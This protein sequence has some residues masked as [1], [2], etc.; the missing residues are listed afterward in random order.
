MFFLLSFSYSANSQSLDCNDPEPICTDT[1]FA[2]T[3]NGN[4]ENVYVTNPGNNYDCLG[5]S[6]SPSWYYLEIEDDGDINMSL[7]APFDIDYI[8]WGP[9]ADL[10]QAEGYCGSLGV[11][12][13]N[14]VT[15]SAASFTFEACD[16]DDIDVFY[17]SGGG[18]WE[19]EISFSISAGGTLVYN[20]GTSPTTGLNTSLTATCT[21]AGSCCTYT[22]DLVDSFGDGWDGST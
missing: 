1:G 21:P 15:N 4:G 3:S 11:T 2:F 9:Y 6:P 17:T 18:L 10:D 16:G 5:F 19:N 20:S 13:S 14:T 8:I 7:T 22:V 12:N